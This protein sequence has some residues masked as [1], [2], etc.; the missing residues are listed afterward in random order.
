MLVDRGIAT[1]T[2]GNGAAGPRM[3]SD[4]AGLLTIGFGGDVDPV[5]VGCQGR[6][7]TQG[8]ADQ[9]GLVDVELIQQSATPAATWSPT[10][11]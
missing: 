4:V 1:V 7:T 5:A 10:P 2:L 8:V 6:R 3:Q 9:V 11:R